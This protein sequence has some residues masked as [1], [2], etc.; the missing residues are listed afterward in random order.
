MKSVNKNEKSFVGIKGKSKTIKLRSGESIMDGNSV[1]MPFLAPY[2][3]SRNKETGALEPL[4]YV[5]YQWTS[6][7]NGVEVTL[8]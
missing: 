2:R 3:I 5:E 6:V 1:Q 8:I 7:E 4:T